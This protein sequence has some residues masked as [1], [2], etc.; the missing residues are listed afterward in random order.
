[1]LIPTHHLFAETAQSFFIFSELAVRLEGTFRL[2]FDII[3]RTLS[4][5]AFLGSLYSD[6]FTVHG[7]MTFPGLCPST[8]LI[9][10][11]IDKGLKLR[12]VKAPGQ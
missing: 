10:A 9:R 7:K 11:I 4:S 5:F 2:R 3:D 1:M 8:E 6:A 12:L